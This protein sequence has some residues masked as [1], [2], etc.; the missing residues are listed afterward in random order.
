MS[1]REAVERVRDDIRRISS[2]PLPLLETV[3]YPPTPTS[4]GL[5][6]REIDDMIRLSLDSFFRRGKRKHASLE[7]HIPKHYFVSRM[8]PFLPSPVLNP[9]RRY[10]DSASMRSV[11]FDFLFC[12]L[13]GGLV[14]ALF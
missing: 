13:S 6:R 2:S 11:S 14:M 3:A 10:Y 4:W 7:I 5:V 12:I 9:G 1:G 8:Y